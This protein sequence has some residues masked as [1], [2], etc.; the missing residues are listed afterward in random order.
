MQALEPT[1]DERMILTWPELAIASA[2]VMIGATVQGSVGFGL[3]LLAAPTLMLI[4]VRMVPGPL[5]VASLVLTLLL[6]HRERAAIDMTGLRWALGGRLVGVVAGASTLAV[7]SRD[8]VAMAFGLMV[9]ASVLLSA[10]GLHVRPRR[11][12]LL[13]A[14]SLSGFMGTVTAV[15]GPP[16]AL[17]YQRADGPRIRGTLSAFFV[18]GISLSLIS[19]R[20]VD[21][22]GLVEL[23]L[24]AVL[25]PGVVA[26]FAASAVT[27][28]VLDR[29]FTR[30]G[31]LLVAGVTGLVVVLRQ[32]F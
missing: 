6:S 29:G 12:T 30:I 13:T 7:L 28:R 31:V 21:R 24:A 3:G 16:M 18:A 20:M 32:L 15:G 23:G 22:L 19:L 25:V 26:G 27:S 17:L 5:L 4:D 10:S 9:L 14:G 1:R 2:V 8:G 11:A